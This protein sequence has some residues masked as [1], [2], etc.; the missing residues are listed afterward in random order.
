[1]PDWIVKRGDRERPVADIAT[2]LFFARDKRLRPDDLV[3]HPV[4]QQWLRAC[5]VLEIKHVFHDLSTDT[6]IGRAE[7]NALPQAADDA[8]PSVSPRAPV[9][10]NDTNLWGASSRV[11]GIIGGGVAILGGTT[12]LGL[13]A[14]GENS[15]IE[16]IAHGLGIYC[17][18]K[19]LFMI[20]AVGNSGRLSISSPSAS[21]GRRSLCACE[22][23]APAPWCASAT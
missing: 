3:F 4:T 15:M 9:L 20:A 8:S 1:M 7:V 18:G 21:R 17:I 19:G 6:P 23:H 13:K 22:S 2:L 14:A 5:D 16:A 10:G 12:L 11:L